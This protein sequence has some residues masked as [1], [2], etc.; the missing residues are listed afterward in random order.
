MSFNRSCPVI[1]LSVTRATAPGLWLIA[2]HLP[3]A[4]AVV[5]CNL[6]VTVRGLLLVGLAVSFFAACCQF[7]TRSGPRGVLGIRTDGERWWVGDTDRGWRA[8]TVDERRCRRLWGLT[9]AWRLPGSEK[10]Q[11][12]IKNY[13][14]KQGVRQLLMRFTLSRFGRRG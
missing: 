11:A 10:Q 9:L 4:A 12:I 8:V 3:A 13:S 7:A 1:A 2:G 5:L 6:P 14:E